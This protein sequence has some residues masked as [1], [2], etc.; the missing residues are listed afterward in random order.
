MLTAWIP[1]VANVMKKC[2][3]L[4]DVIEN[5]PGASDKDINLR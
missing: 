5:S 4:K 1:E 3:N 2:R